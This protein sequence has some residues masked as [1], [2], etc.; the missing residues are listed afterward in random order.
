VIKI[1][2][3]V[4]N[5]GLGKFVKA[6]EKILNEKEEKYSDMW[7]IC[8]LKE[9]MVKLQDQVDS[10]VKL[11]I[12]EHLAMRKFIHIAI[13]CYFLYNRMSE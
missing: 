12:N 1:F 6:M 10:I 4:Q 8:E 9:L 7:T 3:L 5:K 11:D 2:I 13:Y